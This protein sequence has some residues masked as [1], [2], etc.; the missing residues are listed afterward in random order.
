MTEID[1]GSTDLVT[2]LSDYTDPLEGFEILNCAV[3]KAAIFWAH[4]PDADADLIRAVE[5]LEE[6]RR[7]V[8]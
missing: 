4:N 2:A 3:I 5:E 8:G 7:Q 6:Y 1:V